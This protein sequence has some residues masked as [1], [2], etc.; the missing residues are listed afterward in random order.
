MN[1]YIEEIKLNLRRGTAT[2]N[3]LDALSDYITELES[4]RADL[5]LECERLHHE[6]EKAQRGEEAY[7]TLL[8]GAM[9]ALG[10]LPP[11]PKPAPR[12]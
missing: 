11:M 3:E 4:A 12:P 7:K 5:V 8:A 1:K 2:N 10:D 9:V 6:V